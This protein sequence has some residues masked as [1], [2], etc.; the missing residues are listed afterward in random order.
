[1]QLA[2][3]GGVWDLSNLTESGAPG[4]SLAANAL[5]EEH[6]D[7]VQAGSQA[8]V[9]SGS[10]LSQGDVD[11]CSNGSQQNLFG[12]ADVDFDWDCIEPDSSSEMRLAVSRV[13]DLLRVQLQHCS[14]IVCLVMPLS[15]LLKQ[16]I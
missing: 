15:V 2:G 11:S 4:Q 3:Q 10:V 6:I 7:P 14:S 8:S 13:R 5:E 12:G 9:V 16:L 1:M